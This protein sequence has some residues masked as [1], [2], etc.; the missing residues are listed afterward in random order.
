MNLESDNLNKF[1][2]SELFVLGIMNSCFS[3]AIVKGS[4]K[5]ALQSR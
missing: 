2:I 3:F 1:G 4:Q 5:F